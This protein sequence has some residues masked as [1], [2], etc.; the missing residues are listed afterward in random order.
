MIVATEPGSEAVDLD[1]LY[2]QLQTSTM[3]TCLS[4]IMVTLILS[5]CMWIQ[6][7]EGDLQLGRANQI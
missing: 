2:N 7:L 3:L 6:A 4:L 1:E 5:A